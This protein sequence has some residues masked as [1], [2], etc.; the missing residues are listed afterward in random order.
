MICSRTG[1]L[2]ECNDLNFDFY[3]NDFFKNR[4]IWMQWF[5][6]WATSFE[7]S[8]EIICWLKNRKEAERGTASSST[9]VSNIY[10]IKITYSTCIKGT[11]INIEILNLILY[12]N[13][14]FASYKSCIINKRTMGHIN[15]SDEKAVIRFHTRLFWSK[16]SN[17]LPKS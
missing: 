12:H 10:L 3:F 4:C 16:A 15:Y 13:K 6:F 2:I 1:V 7:N 8:S 5:T 14:Y 17:R 9:I 11:F